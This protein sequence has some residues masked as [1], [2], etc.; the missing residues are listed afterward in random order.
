MA[1]RGRR[2]DGLPPRGLQWREHGFPAPP[3]AC[4]ADGGLVVEKLAPKI[5]EGGGLV[6][7]VVLHHR[8]PSNTA[9]N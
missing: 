2:V 6:C 8:W 4:E 7:P 9:P 5:E 1:G 3:A